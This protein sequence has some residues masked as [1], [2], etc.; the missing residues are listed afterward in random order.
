MWDLQLNRN[1][2]ISVG[3]LLSL[4]ILASLSACIRF[5]YTVNLNNSDDFLFSVADVVIW[6][7]AE[8]GI[9]FIVGCISTLRPV[10]RKLFQLGGGN[11]SNRL[12]EDGS[13]QNKG[14][15]SP[16]YVHDQSPAYVGGVCR[17]KTAVT[18]SQFGRKSST[19]SATES[20]EYILQDRSD[21]DL[22]HGIQVQRSVIQSR[23]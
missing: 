5:K 16:R 3:F 21:M 11:N 22:R 6:G 10:F 2:K 8:N 4:G 12:F 9:G 19:D 7:Y 15:T 14:R 1:T 13:G 17:T 23:D 20:E 18:C